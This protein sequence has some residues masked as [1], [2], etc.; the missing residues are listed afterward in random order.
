MIYALESAHFEFEL[1]KLLA[2]TLPFARA[3]K[4]IQSMQSTAADVYL[5]WQA[6]TS[7]LEY[8][9]QENRLKLTVKT[10]VTIRRI[11][12]R[13]FHEMIN[14]APEDIYIIAYIERSISSS[15]RAGYWL[16]PAPVPAFSS[17]GIPETPY[18][19]ASSLNDARENITAPLAYK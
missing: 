14:E 1:T 11:T 15:L 17:S 4:C 9:F 6:V 2:V 16:P 7:Q 19:L 18:F 12:N 13:R 10:M 3:I 8:L 5:F